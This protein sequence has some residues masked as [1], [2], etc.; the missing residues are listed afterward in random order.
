MSADITN[1]SDRESLMDAASDLF[2]LIKVKFSEN[3][4][5]D[6]PYIVLKANYGTYGM[7]VLPIHDP[8]DILSL[9]RRNRNKLTTGKS[10]KSINEFQLQEGI[11]SQHIDGVSKELV[12]YLCADHC[13]GSFYRCHTEKSDRDNL[14]SKGMSFSPICL[15]SSPD[16]CCSM[17]GSPS[18]SD[19]NQFMAFILARLAAASAYQETTQLEASDD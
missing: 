5:S 1:E 11:P 9:N 7:G 17:C 18:L 10:G 2:K 13:L 16:A 6:T 8:L 19:D 4:I 3:N 14:N 12:T 15:A